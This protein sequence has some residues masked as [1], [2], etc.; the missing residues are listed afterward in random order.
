MILTLPVE[1]AVGKVLCHDMT[2]IVPGEGKGPAFRRGHVIAEEDIPTLLS[3]GKEHIYALDLSAGQ[4]HEDDAARRIARAVSGPGLSFS[5]VCEGRVNLIAE[6]GLLSI[7]VEALHR[8]NSIENVALSTLHTNQFID[9]ARPIAGTRVIPLVVEEA[10]IEQVEAIAAEAWPVIQVKPLARLRVGVVTTGSEVYHGRIKDKFGPVLRRK[11]AALGSEVMDQVLVSDDPAMT[12]DAI[13]RFV[14]QGAEMVVVTGGMSVDPDDQ[15][16]AS[17]RATGA[18]VVSYGSPTFPGAMFLLAYLGGVP[19]LG[20]PGCV[21]YHRA[22]VF[23]LVVPRILA[24]EQISRRDIVELGHGGFCA[25]CDE[26]RYPVCP[27]GKC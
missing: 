15:T 9:S 26:C 24:G 7:D 4:L 18:E 1:E 11:F 21:M 8:I 12:R 19:V 25:G 10:L 16:P 17:I 13:L 20:L 6:P 22:S 27:F 2:R 14:E 5:E 3:I 23:D